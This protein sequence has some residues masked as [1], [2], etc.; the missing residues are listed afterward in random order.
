MKSV[1]VV[2]GGLIVICVLLFMG[3]TT[4]ETDKIKESIVNIK[5]QINSLD[6]KVDS[7]TQDVKMSYSNNYTSLTDNISYWTFA[8]T[9]Y[10][11]EN[12]AMNFCDLKSRLEFIDNKINRLA[13]EQGLEFYIKEAEIKNSSLEL[14]KV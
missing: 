10:E 9:S 12:S 13:K 2:F 7:I 6:S 1:N 3:A 5:E 4:Y 8:S 14:K 11:K